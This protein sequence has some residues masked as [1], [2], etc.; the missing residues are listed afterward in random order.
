VNALLLDT[1]AV[2]WR[3]EQS[4]EMPSRVHELITKH[5]MKGDLL[6]ST[7]SLVEI[8]YLSERGRISPT[9][10]QD[11]AAAISNERTALRL[12]DL[13]LEIALRLPSVPRSAIPD[14]PDRILAAT[15]LSLGIPLVTR[16]EKIRA[17]D[18][19]MTIW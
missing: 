4:S 5:E 2:V 1:H 13:S 7:I 16:D 6:V 19:I 12:V 9:C 10:L 14:M 18:A 15:A 11:V 8:A 17:F 3:L